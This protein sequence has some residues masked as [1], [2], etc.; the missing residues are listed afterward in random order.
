MTEQSTYSIRDLEELSGIPAHTIRTWERRYRLLTP[1]R[2]K[3]NARCYRAADV[4]FLNHLA[5]LLKQGHKIST[6]AGKSREEISTLAHEAAL[7]SEDS[8]VIE[9]LCNALQDYDVTKVESLMSCYIRKEGFDK[10]VSVRFAPFLNRLNLLLLSGT[11]HP[12][13]A[14]MFS[15]KLRQKIYAALD[16]TV[17]PRDAPRWILLHDEAA[18]DTI[19]ADI[20]QY[21]LRKA[22]K[23]VLF[24]GATVPGGIPA[25]ISE[26]MPDGFCLIAGGEYATD[27]LQRMIDTFTQDQFKSVNTL[28]FAPGKTFSFVNASQYPGVVVFS[29]LEEAF[30]HFAQD[31]A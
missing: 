4:S 2:N 8:D 7:T 23:Q 5:A 13:H 17:P 9:T 14:Q 11:L 12:V 1:A 29:G 27:W 21:I 28:V 15:T 20:L 26:A 30:N 3:C 24:A 25:F 18:T 6:L 31:V 22:G 10:A 16:T 19:Y